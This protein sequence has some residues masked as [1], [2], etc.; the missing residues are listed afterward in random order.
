MKTVFVVDDS[1]I[2]LMKADEALSDHYNVFTIA[3]AFT[4]FKLFDDIIPDVILLD[5]LMP[6]INGY[7]VLKRLKA[8]ERYAGI[9]VIFLTSLNEAADEDYG[10]EIGAVDFIKKPFSE[11]ILLDRIKIVLESGGALC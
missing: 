2:N 3:S 8:D 9:P 1:G 10:Y 5:I 11:Q 4:M 7:D 6:D